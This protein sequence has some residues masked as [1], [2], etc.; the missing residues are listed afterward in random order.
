MGEN[1][2]RVNKSKVSQE[3]IFSYL[4]RRLSINSLF[5]EGIPVNYLHKILFLTLIAIIYIANNHW[6]ER[7]I[8]KIDKMQVEVEELRADYTSL[9]SE[10]MFASKQTEVA[11]KVKKLGLKESFTPPNKIIDDIEY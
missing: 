2:V 10:Y 11:R 4:Q 9:K 5:D 6:A 1:T 8:R 3:G 7:M